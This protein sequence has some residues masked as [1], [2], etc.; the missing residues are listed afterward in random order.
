MATLQSFHGMLSTKNSAPHIL[1]SLVTVRFAWMHGK[2]HKPSLLA[3]I[4]SNGRAGR[5]DHDLIM[6]FGYANYTYDC[7]PSSAARYQ[8]THCNPRIDLSHAHTWC[9][10]SWQPIHRTAPLLHQ[11]VHQPPEDGDFTP[12]FCISVSRLV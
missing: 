6:T 5:L 1:F 10:H 8:P 3:C 4:Q 12:P 11:A 9:H 2:S 7:K